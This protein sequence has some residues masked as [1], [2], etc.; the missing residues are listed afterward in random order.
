[1]GRPS[2]LETGCSIVSSSNNVKTAQLLNG[3]SSVLELNQKYQ[4]FCRLVT[5]EEKEFF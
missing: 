4:G 5:F 2:G 1:V 3:K